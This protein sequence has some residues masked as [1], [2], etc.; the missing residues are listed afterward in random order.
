MFQKLLCLFLVLAALSL[1]ALPVRAADSDD[2]MRIQVAVQLELFRLSQQSVSHVEPP[3]IAEIE[4]LPAAPPVFR[5]VGPNLSGALGVSERRA[6]IA[7]AEQAAQ[8]TIPIPAARLIQDWAADEMT[9]VH[10]GGS[11]A[12]AGHAGRS[13]G[14]FR[15]RSRGG[16]GG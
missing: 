4:G 15:G 13:R 12:I 8:A 2:D 9:A 14:L 10:H 16:C 1:V 3:V 7:T 6:V 5:A 11:R